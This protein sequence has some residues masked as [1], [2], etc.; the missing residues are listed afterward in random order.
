MA[1]SV[2][3]I[4]SNWALTQGSDVYAQLRQHMVAYKSLLE[5]HP[6]SPRKISWSS[7]ACGLGLLAVGPWGC[8]GVSGT[9]L[10]AGPPSAAI[11]RALAAD[12]HL[13]V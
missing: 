1:K 10:R 2:H 12:H 13:R 7:A 8:G 6:A 5:T 9:V 4:A 3:P 11:D